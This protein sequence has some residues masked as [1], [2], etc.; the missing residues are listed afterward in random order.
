MFAAILQ[1]ALAAAAPVLVSREMLLDTLFSRR[2]LLLTGKGGVGKSVVGAALAV[3][4]RDRGKRVLLVEVAAPVEAARLLGAPPSRGRETEVLPGL[5]TVNLDPASVMDEYVRH[6]V[7]LEMLTRRI[8]ESPIYHRFFAAAPGLKELMVL[9]KVMVL[10]EA[11]ARFS[12]KPL[13]D[14]VVLDAP[15]TGHGLAFLK[16]PLVASAAVPVGPV[17]HN[18]RRV[19]AMLRDRHRTALVLVAVPEEMAV[20]EAVQFHALA[21]EELD[22][23]PAAVVLN[24]CHER[25]FD[26]E[27]E[28]DVL[29]LTAEGAGGTIAPDA[30]LDAA[31]R[32]ARRQIR[33]RKLTRFYRDRLR[34]ALGGP[35]VSLP[36]LFREA[37]GPDDVRLLAG[38]LAAA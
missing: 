22:M 29:R 21:T 38:R 7:K 23:E 31:L 10:E 12:H 6:V 19:L 11:R 3:A 28:A 8:L 1:H 20:V 18:A 9:G 13:W 30:P 25:R 24:A 33:R 14:L 36:F 32:A 34:R 17:G 27:D 4:A 37:L 2:V 15:A 26:D 5:F 16:V 35:L